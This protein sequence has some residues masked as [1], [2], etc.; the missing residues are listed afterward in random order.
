MIL[1]GEG[2]TSIE[3]LDFETFFKA[4]PD[5]YKDLSSKKV[6]II[7]YKEDITKDDIEKVPIS[8]K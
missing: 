4:Q 1:I 7:Y 6:I 3:I 5:K 2:P 8:E